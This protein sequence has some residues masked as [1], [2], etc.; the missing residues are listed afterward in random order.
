MPIK[1]IL[2]SR[3]FSEADGQSLSW[4]IANITWPTI[5]EEDKFLTN[6]W[7]PV[8]QNLHVSVQPTWLEI[9]RVPLSSS[10]IHT[11]STSFPSS[12]FNSH[13]IVPSW[14]WCVEEIFGLQILKFFDRRDL[15]SFE[16]F[17]I[18]LKS[19]VPDL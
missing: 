1:T 16:I 12:S 18:S 3:R 2:V 9:Q 15:N 13:L 5:S 11:V 17:V 6:L 4:S 19:I 10:G 14:D 8:W 7:V